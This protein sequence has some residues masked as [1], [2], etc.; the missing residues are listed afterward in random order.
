[1]LDP[2]LSLLSHVDFWVGIVLGAIGAW[3]ADEW[4]FPR[5]A[6]RITARRFRR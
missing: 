3:S 2:F 1:M 5:I 6:S 4:L